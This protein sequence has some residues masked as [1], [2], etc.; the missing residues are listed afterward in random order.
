MT[1]GLK[2]SNKQLYNFIGK[3]RAPKHLKKWLTE[4][5]KDKLMD[6]GILNDAILKKVN[7]LN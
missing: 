5:K 2:K 7:E 1:K 3:W 6:C 4:D